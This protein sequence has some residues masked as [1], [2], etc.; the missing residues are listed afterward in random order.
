M[1]KDLFSV[2]IFFI[3]FRETL[4]AAIIISVLLSL[5]KQLVV[6]VV[7][8]RTSLASADT[9]GD[10]TLIQSK[11]AE[12]EDAPKFPHGNH[13]VD[14]HE[15]VDEDISHAEGRQRKLLKRLYI[16][17]WAGA[18]TGL[19]I[20]LCIGAAFIAVFYTT[21][22]DLYGQSEDLWEGIFSLVA[23]VM[24]FIMGITMMRVDRAKIQW[25]YK[26]QTA[27]MNKGKGVS[28]EGRSSR[29]ALFILPL[30]TVLREGLEAV[31]FVAGVTLGQQATSIPIAAIVGILCGFL[32]GFLIYKSSSRINLSIFLVVSTNFLL[33]IGAGLFSKAVLN[34]QNYKFNQLTGG[35][36]SESGSGPGS[37]P[38]AGN[39]WHVN[40]GNPELKT[41]VGL[42][43]LIFN[44]I[45]GWTNSATVGTILSYVF[46]WIAVT[47]VLVYMKWSEGRT[48]FFG[49]KS[50]AWHRRQARREKREQV[51]VN[52]FSRTGSD[53]KS[54]ASGT[55]SSP[56]SAAPLHVLH[57]SDDEGIAIEEPA[58]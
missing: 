40:Y 37:Y 12:K 48:H 22:N 1:T 38:V 15:L 20:A 11:E 18:L 54:T 14:V 45:L 36:A 25:K 47:V 31:V 41:D 16:Q 55:A 52:S 13:E 49:L 42:G 28:S 57:R 24:I 34:F 23:S 44:A 9:G 2:P 8:V 53:D 19:F 5:A 46:Y 56:T 30:I 10:T 21:L 17:I 39:V 32:V 3:L 33:L 27:F 29:W 58:K 43:W 35:D 51:E 4:E 50:A 26:L 7:P 6:H